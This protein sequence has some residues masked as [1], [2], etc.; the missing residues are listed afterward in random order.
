MKKRINNSLSNYNELSKRHKE[1]VPDFE[2]NCDELVKCV[3]KN[4]LVIDMILQS[5][6]HMFVN[7]EIGDEIVSEN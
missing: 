6:E 4:I 3:D 2:A 5:V 1:L 7:Q